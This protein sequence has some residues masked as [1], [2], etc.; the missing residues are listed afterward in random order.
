MKANLRPLIVLALESEGQGLLESLGH[1]VV[2]C[3]VGKVN[4]AYHLARALH[5]GAERYNLVLN[6][7]S[8]GSSVFACGS[9]VEISYCVQRDMDASGIGFALGETPFDTAPAALACSRR[10]HHLPAGVCG[11]GDSFVQGASPVACDVVDMEAYALAKVCHLENIA[12]SSVKYITDGA[13]DGAA[14]DWQENLRHAA[15]AFMALLQTHL[16][17]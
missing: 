7:G 4:A 8:A 3:G 9:V 12:F 11:S 5:V 14:V 15:H 16:S 1:D 6:L 17:S 10:F 13:D 2:Y